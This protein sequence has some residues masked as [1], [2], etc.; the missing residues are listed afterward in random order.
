VHF[1]SGIFECPVYDRDHLPIDEMLEG[2]LVIE[3]RVSTTI[4]HPGDRVRLIARGPIL[5]EVGAA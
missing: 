2:P 3:E 1:Y 4:V 5:I